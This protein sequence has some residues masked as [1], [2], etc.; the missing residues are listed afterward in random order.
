MKTMN[1]EVAGN[2]TTLARQNGAD[3]FRSLTLAIIGCG[4]WGINHVRTAHEI[5]GANLQIV[6]DHNAEVEQKL[7]SIS[8]DISLTNDSEK[9]YQS[10]DINCVI[11]A[12]PA[13]TH[14]EIAKRCLQAGKHVLVEKPITLNTAHATELVR[15]SEKVKRVLM[16]GHV[17]L[18]HPA[19]VKLKQEISNGRVGKIQYM[20]SN[21]LNLGAIRSEENILWSFAPHDISI[22]QYLTESYPIYVDAKGT[23]CLQNNVEDTTLTYLIYPNNIHAHIFVSWLHPFKE[24]RLIVVGTR[25]MMAFEDSSSTDKLKFYPNGFQDTHGEYVKFEGEDEVVDYENSLP[26][27]NEQLHFYNAVSGKTKPLSDGQHALE[28]LEIL[29]RA[30]SRLRKYDVMPSVLPNGDFTE[31]E[32]VRVLDNFSTGRHGNLQDFNSDR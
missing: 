6:C 11:I 28:V 26:L 2:G 24:H 14:Y 19:I 17:L 16:V 21:R 32:E 22:M 4:R 18:Y 8:Q 27:T 15:I 31:G 5:L 20:Y 3:D 9:I 7:N 1:S 25:G 13:A 29:E 30:Q 23:N 10:P 12:T